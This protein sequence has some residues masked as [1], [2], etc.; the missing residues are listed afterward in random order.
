MRHAC[1]VDRAY[2]DNSRKI[3]NI[4]RNGFSVKATAALIKKKAAALAA[5]AKFFL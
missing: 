4:V 1:K 3:G 2:I 5:T